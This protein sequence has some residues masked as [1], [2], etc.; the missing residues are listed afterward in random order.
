MLKF[1]YEDD[2][3][4]ILEVEVSGN[5]YKYDVENWS[6]EGYHYE[7]DIEN[8]ECMIF[9]DNECMHHDNIKKDTLS[10]IFEIGKSKLIDRYTCY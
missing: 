1:I 9:K 7:Y 5:F 3:L 6:G 4:G 10:D 8:M 2:D